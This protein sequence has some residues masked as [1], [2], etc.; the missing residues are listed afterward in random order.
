M[1]EEYDSLIRNETWTLSDLP[2]GR[3]AINCKWVYALKTKPDDTIDTIDRYKARLVANGCSQKFGT[4]FHETYSLTV[5]FDSIRLVLAIVAREDMHIRQF[6]IKT[7]FLHGQLHEETYMKQ[8]PG[9]E[10]PQNPT[11]WIARSESSVE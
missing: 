3:K 8:V 2:F 6:D 11:T 10:D 9:F 7:V 5:K 4:D 1:R